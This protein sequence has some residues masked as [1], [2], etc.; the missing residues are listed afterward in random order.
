[1]Q[2]PVRLPLGFAGGLFDADTGLTRFVWR[3]Y[4]AETG[5]FT[6]LDPLGARGGDADWYGYC[7]DDPVN[8]VDAWGLEDSWVKQPSCNPEYNECMSAANFWKRQCKQGAELL[9]YLIGDKR[10]VRGTIAGEVGDWL[11]DKTHEANTDR[12][13]EQYGSQK[14]DPETYQLPDARD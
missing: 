7:V 3:D 12:C 5:R 10:P 14:Q 9:G 4:D 6:A 8:R 11:C 1:M 13:E 2:G